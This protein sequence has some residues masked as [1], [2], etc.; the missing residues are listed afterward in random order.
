MV[1]YGTA[2]FQKYNIIRPKQTKKGTIVKKKNQT[3]NIKRSTSASRITME[4]NK[5]SGSSKNLNRLMSKK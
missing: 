2:I 5:K 1:R 4:T 3:D